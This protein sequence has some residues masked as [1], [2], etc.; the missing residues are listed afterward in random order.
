MIRALLDT[1]TL[2]SGIYKAK[3][4]AGIILRLGFA[5]AYEPCVTEPIMDELRDVLDRPRARKFLYGASSVL[6]P[7]SISDAW[8][9]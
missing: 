9:G 5:E 4:T 7:G 6:T 8:P 1:N 3:G 2:F